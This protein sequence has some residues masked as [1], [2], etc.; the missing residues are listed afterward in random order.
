MG[1]GCSLPLAKFLKNN[2]EMQG[3]ASLSKH[4]MHFRYYEIH[5]SYKVR[6][7]WLTQANL[8]KNQT[9]RRDASITFRLP[10][11][12][13]FLDVFHFFY[14]SFH[15]IQCKSHL[16]CYSAHCITLLYCNNFVFSAQ[17]ANEKSSSFFFLTYFLKCTIFN[18][19]FPKLKNPIRI[20]SYQES[21]NGN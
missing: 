18:L 10:Y 14:I 2:S 16:Y 21:Q 17:G 4:S 19:S 3:G 1:E 5:C 11:Y 13:F 7:D 12:W 20:K 8:S 6:E 9:T 15:L